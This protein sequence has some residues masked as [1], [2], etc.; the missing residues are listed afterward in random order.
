MA[1][2]FQEGQGMPLKLKKYINQVSLF[3]YY[4]FIFSEKETNI[5]EEQKQSD[6]EE[7]L[8][9]NNSDL[10]DFNVTLDQIDDTLDQFYEWS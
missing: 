5:E 4:V 3:K 2:S 6:Q 1:I 8:E 9:I 7:D 10:E